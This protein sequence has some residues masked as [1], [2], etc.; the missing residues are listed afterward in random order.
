VLV[1]FPAAYPPTRNAAP[2]YGPMQ[3]VEMSPFAFSATGGRPDD[4]LALVLFRRQLPV[5]CEEEAERVFLCPHTEGS[6]HGFIEGV[7]GVPQRVA[8]REFEV[9]GTWRGGPDSSERAFL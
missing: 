5:Q 2:R 9:R 3:S 4:L 8:S 7:V 1:L 6:P